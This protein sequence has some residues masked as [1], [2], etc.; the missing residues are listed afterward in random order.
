M[1]LKAGVHTQGINFYYVWMWRE[2]DWIWVFIRFELFSYFKEK[3]Y[4]ALHTSLSQ[5]TESGQST[6]T[7]VHIIT[8]CSVT[9]LKSVLKTK[10][11]YRPTLI[12]KT[13]VE[14]YL[15]YTIVLQTKPY[16]KDD[17]LLGYNAV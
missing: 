15:A 9:S 7:I 14:K 1:I 4:N 8:A 17:S 11:W 6:V 13:R 5:L 3:A 12:V 2:Q 16:I 10:S